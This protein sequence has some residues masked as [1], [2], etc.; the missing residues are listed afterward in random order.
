MV[1]NRMVRRFCLSLVAVA[2]VGLLAGSSCGGLQLNLNFK[3]PKRAQ[4]SNSRMVTMPAGASLVVVNDVGSTRVTVDP[5]AT[6][7]TVE[8]TRTAY[9]DTQAAADDLLAKIVVTITEPT[10]GDN[11][12]GISAP[13]PAEASDSG[14]DFS[15]TTNEDE[16][17]VISINNAVLVAQ[18]QLRIT[19][20]PNTAVDVT[21]K[22]G[23]IR[24]VT[25]DTDSRLE[26]TNGSIRALGSEA[27]ITGLTDVGAIVVSSHRGGLDLSTHAGS[28]TA[29]VLDLNTSESLIAR[30]ET[31]AID[32]TLPRGVDADLEA[33]T[34]TGSIDFSKRRFTATSNVVQTR[35]TLSATLNDGGAV[36]D[37]RAEVGSIEINSR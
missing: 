29:E 13:K 9:A 4:D 1:R 36:I 23:P 20:P 10:P 16:V 35:S 18:V 11:V 14:A 2:G 19:L 28:I 21:Q 27:K 33:L 15:V 26:T 3:I 6:K 12:L 34:E 8:V 30:T 22:N 17:T 5:A 37:L 24:A 32:V 31:G 7:A 25:L